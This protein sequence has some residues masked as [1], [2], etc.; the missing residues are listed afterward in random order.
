M[1]TTY[2]E[3]VKTGEHGEQYRIH[4]IYMYKKTIKKRDSYK[5]DIEESGTVLGRDGNDIALE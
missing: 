2:R 4:D 1:G 3:N 5:S